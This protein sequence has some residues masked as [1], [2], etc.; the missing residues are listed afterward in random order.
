MTFTAT[1][2]DFEFYLDSLKLYP[3]KMRE[4]KCG[5]TALIHVKTPPPKAKFSRVTKATDCWVAVLYPRDIL[6]PDITGNF[7]SKREPVSY[8]HDSKK[9]PTQVFKETTLGFTI[10]NTWNG[11]NYVLYNEKLDWGTHLGNFNTLE[12]A[13]R[14]LVRCYMLANLP[15]FNAHIRSRM[16]G[17]QGHGLMHEFSKLKHSIKALGQDMPNWITCS[18]DINMVILVHGKEL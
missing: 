17:G 9:F 10:S 6:N 3:I 8:T 12:D 16:R 15:H 18:A 13:Q 1:L 5:F 7:F 2:K 4:D 14:E 11:D